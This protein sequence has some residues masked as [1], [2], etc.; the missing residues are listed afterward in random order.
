MRVPVFLLLWLACGTAG[1]LPESLPVP[2]GV[3]VIPLPGTDRPAATYRGSPVMVTREDGRW[4]AVVGI[5]LDTGPGPETLRVSRPDA[6]AIT[7]RF[8]VRDRQYP[9][10]RIQLDNERMV[11]PYQDD[12]E[13]IRRE[14]G[15]I[16]AALNRWREEPEPGLDFRLPVE[17][18]ESSAFGLRRY[19]NDQPRKPH[20]GLDLAAE[21]GTPVAAP[22]GGLITETG[23]YF[24]NGNTV[25]VDHG[26]GLV[27]MYCHLSEIAVE[28]GRRVDAG[29]TIG[30]VGATG[31]VTGAHLHWSVSLNGNMVDPHLFLPPRATA[32]APD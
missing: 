7:L 9:E 22:A 15:R 28:P 12:L 14:S 26:Q 10:Q 16:R 32:T 13:R 3:A 18:P 19:F 24:F 21:A 31:R 27:S 30:R 8:E 20:S 1:A 4:F 29:D 25:F 6:E 17:A 5:G 2:G 11:N 23:D